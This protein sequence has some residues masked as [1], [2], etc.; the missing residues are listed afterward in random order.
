MV[1]Q[2]IVLQ[3]HIKSVFSVHEKRGEWQTT[4]NCCSLCLTKGHESWIWKAWRRSYHL[5][6]FLGH[7]PDIADW[8]KR[9]SIQ[10]PTLSLVSSA[11]SEFT[12]GPQRLSSHVRL[13]GLASDKGGYLKGPL[14]S[15]ALQGVLCVSRHSSV[16]CL[17]ITFFSWQYFAPHSLEW[18]PEEGEDIFI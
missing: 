6:S 17:I 5:S 18:V 3:L 8:R 16:W 9:L 14:R 4:R 10:V 13:A 7:C 12:T 15:M 1:F 11:T 2:Q